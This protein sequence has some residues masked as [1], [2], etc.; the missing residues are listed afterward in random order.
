[1]TKTYMLL[2]LMA[3]IAAMSHVKFDSASRKDKP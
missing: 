1:M 3:A 2:M